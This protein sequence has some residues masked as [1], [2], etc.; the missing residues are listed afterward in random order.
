MPIEFMLS[1][2]FLKSGKFQT[3]LILLGITVGVSILVF[4]GSLIDGLQK[5]LINRTIGN[6]PHIVITS[7]TDIPRAQIEGNNIYKNVKLLKANN[8][9]NNIS[10]FQDY[11][12]LIIKNQNVNVISPTVTASGFINKSKSNSPITIK[13]INLDKAD[14]IYNVKDRIISGLPI[15][16]GNNILIG[17]SIANDLEIKVNDIVTVTTPNGNRDL[18]TVSGIFDLENES[19]NKTWALI[20]INRAQKLLRLDGDISSI[21]IQV[22]EVFSAEDTSKSLERVL[23]EDFNVESWQETNAQILTALNSQSSSTLLIQ[24]FV[25]I[26]VTLGIASVLAISVIQKSRQ[27]GILKAMGIK[28]KSASFIFLIQGFLLGFV[29]SIIGSGFGMLLSK[30]FVTFVRQDNGEPLF[31]IDIDLKQI[32]VVILISTLASTFAAIVPARRSARLNPIEVIR[33]G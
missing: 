2:K 17:K 28:T 31:P 12:Q 13:G 24:V 11:N 6:S 5:D 22:N 26:A 15:I 20:E 9:D 32:L 27:I 7:K 16:S 25:V 1:W 14:K 8:Q 23:N 3:I 30:L 4:I 21:E 10:S 29:G 33:N 19:I 18:F